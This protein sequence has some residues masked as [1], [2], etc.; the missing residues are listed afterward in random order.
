MS[1]LHLDSPLQSREDPSGSMVPR[2][3]AS[4]PG[5]SAGCPH[6]G[7]GAEWG[8][9]GSHAGTGVWRSWFVGHMPFALQGYSHPLG[10]VQL[11]W[12]VPRR[13]VTYRGIKDSAPS[14][15]C[16]LFLDLNLI[17][18]SFLWHP[19]YFRI[20]SLPGEI[21]ATRNRS[22]GENMPDIKLIRKRWGGIL[23][24]LFITYK[25][26]IKMLVIFIYALCMTYFK[27]IWAYDFQFTKSVSP[28]PTHSV[29]IWYL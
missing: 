12:Y 26:K 6:V 15:S 27:W 19:P 14:S 25:G 16:P 1:N 5:P 28:T 4:G 17:A 23:Q 9:L 13:K 10:S 8:D 7:T 24:M 21:L 18:A 2:V 3:K 11:C 29:H 20:L 22:V